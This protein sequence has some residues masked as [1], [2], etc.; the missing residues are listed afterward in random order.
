M[1]PFAGD[2]QI[3]W[4]DV[5]MSQSVHGLQWNQSKRFHNTLTPPA[6]LKL[7]AISDKDHTAGAGGGARRLPSLAWLYTL[8]R[9]PH[10]VPWEM[11]EAY[12]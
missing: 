6:W 3:T 4:G 12:C 2:R 7:A 1:S 8:F 11:H 9:K 5:G 10:I